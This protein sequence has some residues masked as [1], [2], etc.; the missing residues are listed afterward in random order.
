VKESKKLPTEY[1]LLIQRGLRHSRHKRVFKWNRKT[2]KGKSKKDTKGYLNEK[3]RPKRVRKR[4]KK[5]P[6][7]YLNEK[8]KTQR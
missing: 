5:D 7:G 4:K 1:G 2:L 6:K 8:T 3:K